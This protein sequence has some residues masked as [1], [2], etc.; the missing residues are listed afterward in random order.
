LLARTLPPGFG[1]A[2]VET[3]HRHK[4]DAPSGTARQLAAAWQAAR[5]GETVP[6]AALR[7]GGIFG[8]H[9]WTLADDEET[10]VLTHRA[11]SR[12]AF[13]RGVPPAIRFA[14]TAAP[15]LYGMREVL[16]AGRGA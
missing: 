4:R 15:G 10:L 3:H 14:A 6:I 12:R 9:A 13:T 5:G 2:Q 1:A 7:L 8:E 11:H 16:A